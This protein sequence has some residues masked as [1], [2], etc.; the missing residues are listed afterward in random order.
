VLGDVDLAV[1]HHERLR[2]HSWQP[3]MAGEASTLGVDDHHLGQPHVG[4]QAHAGV[5]LRRRG[6]SLEEHDRGV[7]RLGRDC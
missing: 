7:D 6:D 1:V 4:K 3:L 2:R 5:A